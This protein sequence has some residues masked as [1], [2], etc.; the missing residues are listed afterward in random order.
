MAADIKEAVAEK[1]HTR[2]ATTGII[3]KINASS[4]I[5]VRIAVRDQRGIGCGGSLAEA[6]PTTVAAFVPRL[7]CEGA[8]ACARVASKTGGTRRSIAS[9][10]TGVGKSAIAR[11]RSV[12]ELCGAGGRLASDCAVV[13]EK[14][15]IA[16]VGRVGEGD[17]AA[18]EKPAVACRRVFEEADKCEPAPVEETSIAGGRVI[19]EFRTATAEPAARTDGVVNTHIARAGAVEELCDAAWI[20]TG[21]GAAVSDVSPIPRSRAVSELYRSMLCA[22]DIRGSHKILSDPGIIRDP[23]TADGQRQCG[24][25][26]NRERTRARIES[27]TDHFR[28]S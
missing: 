19:V 14:S 17:C 5:S 1:L 21:L 4:S 23:G 24:A 3:K 26:G 8:I 12:G 9:L 25:G 13:V 16:R 11:G 18:V 7:A 10:A 6:D 27:D 28:V 15:A 20:I 2:L 22:V